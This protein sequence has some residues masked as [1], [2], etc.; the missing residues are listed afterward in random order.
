MLAEYHQNNEVK[1]ALERTQQDSRKAGN[2]T[3]GCVWANQGRGTS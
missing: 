2:T 1:P 3:G